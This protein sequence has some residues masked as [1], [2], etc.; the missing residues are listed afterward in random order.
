MMEILSIAMIQLDKLLFVV[1]YTNHILRMS[2][3][4]KENPLVD[5]D[6]SLQTNEERGE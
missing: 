6:G 1:V 4:E 3:I 5:T 2:V